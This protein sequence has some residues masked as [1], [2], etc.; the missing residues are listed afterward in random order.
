MDGGR[1]WDD[2]ICIPSL[3]SQEETQ[4]SKQQ[5]NIGLIRQFWVCHSHSYH[6][7]PFN[8][9]SLWHTKKCVPNGSCLVE[10]FIHHTTCSGLIAARTLVQAQHKSTSL[11]QRHLWERE[12]CI[13]HLCPLMRVPCL[14]ASENLF[15]NLSS[16]NL[17]IRGEK[18]LAGPWMESLTH[19][20]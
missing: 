2:L 11:H 9:F 8:M 3:L 6:S 5:L 10:C 13:Q 20:M 17:E 7:Y 19:Q 4:G 15:S 1:D 18:P 16:V 12:L 14:A